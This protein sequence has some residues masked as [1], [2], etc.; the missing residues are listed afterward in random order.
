M[1]E[2]TM[3]PEYTSL[4]VKRNPNIKYIKAETL[5]KYEKIRDQQFEQQI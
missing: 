2:N 5:K 4:K 1:C 3:N